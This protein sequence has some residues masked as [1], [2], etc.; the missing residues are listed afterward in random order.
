MPPAAM[1]RAALVKW[2]IF[3]AGTAVPVTGARAAM[4]SFRP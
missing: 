1:R 2:N 4:S 3:Y